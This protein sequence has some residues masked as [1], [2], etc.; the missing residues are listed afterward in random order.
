MLPES[1]NHFNEKFKLF[2]INIPSGKPA[3]RL[4]TA[5]KRPLKSFNTKFNKSVN[6]PN[7]GRDEDGDPPKPGTAPV[8]PLN[9]DSG[10]E[11]PPPPPSNPDTAPN[12]GR[13]PPKRPPASPGNC[14]S[15]LR[16]GPSIGILDMM[17]S[18]VIILRSVFSKS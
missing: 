1:S 10:E 5:D 6:P 8:K 4:G 14:K 9:A 16:R 11:D 7:P 17:F 15:P 3:S 13:P 2:R 12:P 18:I